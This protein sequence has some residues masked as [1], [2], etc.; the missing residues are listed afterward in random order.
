MWKDDEMNDTD[1]IL[2]KKDG[3]KY[4]GG[5]KNGVKHGKCVE[6]NKDGLRFEGSYNNGVRDGAYTERDKTGKV[7]SK[8]K[9]VS[10]KKVED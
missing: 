4:R 1:G 9:Y 3:E 6:V 2:R 7:V 10:G 5:F 8:G